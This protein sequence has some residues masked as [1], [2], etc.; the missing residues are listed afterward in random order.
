M[1]IV[2][3]QLALICLSE[4][5]KISFYV[6]DEW[7]YNNWLN[8]NQNIEKDKKETDENLKGKKILIE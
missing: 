1:A 8:I 2:M 3:F 4:T 6:M 7:L 5:K